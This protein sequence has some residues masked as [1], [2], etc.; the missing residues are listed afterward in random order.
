MNSM[1][2]ISLYVLQVMPSAGRQPDDP[3]APP[4]RTIT[5]DSDTSK[6]SIWVTMATDQPGFLFPGAPR[7][8]NPPPRRRIIT[9]EASLSWSPSQDKANSYTRKPATKLLRP[10][11][12]KPPSNKVVT[13]VYFE[14]YL[15]STLY[16]TTTSMGT[17]LPDE[18]IAGVVTLPKERASQKDNEVRAGEEQQPSPAGTGTVDNDLPDTPLD[19]RTTITVDETDKDTTSTS[20]PSR[21]TLAPGSSTNQEQLYTTQP[22]FNGK[23][24]YTV[25]PCF[26]D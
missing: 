5:S 24:A 18:E 10:E 9:E 21:T 26:H 15:N 13:D 7:S 17:P 22:M 23:A 6:S 8:T 1:H 20:G 16:K 12:A 4:D 3:E 11:G 14:E 2:C 25:A 19:V